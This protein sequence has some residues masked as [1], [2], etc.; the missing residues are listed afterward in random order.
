MM[1]YKN[2]FQ[3][4]SYNYVE[5]SPFSEWWKEYEEGRR[6]STKMQRYEQNT[7]EIDGIKLTS[8]QEE[9]K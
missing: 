5:D 6:H 3:G 8:I 9:N 4:E 2:P 7:M 1:I